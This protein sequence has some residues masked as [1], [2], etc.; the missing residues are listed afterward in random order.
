MTVP[1]PRHLTLATKCTQS[2]QPSY[3][4]RACVG[5]LSPLLRRAQAQACCEHQPHARQHFE[6][7]LGASLFRHYTRVRERLARLAKQVPNA[8]ASLIR[9]APS[10]RIRSSTKMALAVIGLQFAVERLIS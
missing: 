3:K 2:R 6:F 9:V 1:E 7:D 8:L 4:L 10:Y 5:A